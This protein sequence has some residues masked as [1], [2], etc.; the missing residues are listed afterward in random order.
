[1]RGATFLVEQEY[2]NEIFL[3]DDGNLDLSRFPL[4]RNRLF[5]LLQSLDVTLNGI[6]GHGTRVLQV[7]TLCYKTGQR[8]N[9]DRIPAM[10]VGFKK[11][12]V[13]VYAILAVLH[14]MSISRN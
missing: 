13:L 5:R 3:S 7:F 2:D 6:F 4:Y 10:L 1:V 8:W 14:I 9:G 12:G 11:G